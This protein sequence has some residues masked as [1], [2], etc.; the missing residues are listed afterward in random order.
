MSDHKPFRVPRRGFMG[1]VAGGVMAAATSNSL[2]QESIGVS[3]PRKPNVLFVMTDQQRADTI[4]ALGNPDIYSPNFDRLVARGVSFSNGY[5][6]CPVCVPAR[7][8]IRTG[9][10]MPTTGVYHNGAPNLVEGQSEN[11]E[12]RCGPYLA[13]TMAANGYRTFG[14]G[15]FHTMPRFE[16]VGYHVHLHSEEIYGTPEDRANDAFAQYIARVC[17]AYDFQEGLMGE[18]TEMYYMPQ[19]SAMPAE[20]T[21][22][23]W[24]AARAVEQIRRHD[25]DR[26]YFGFV[27]FVGPH[28]PFAPPI[29]FNRMYDPDR[30]P[31]PVRGDRNLDLM[32][33]QLRWMNHAIF[34]DDIS[35]SHARV[36][37]ARYYGELT[38][39]DHCL[40]MILDAVD[41]RDDADNTLICFYS[42]HGDHLGDH[43]AWQK[44]S[45][46]QQSCN[47]PFLLSWPE[48]LPAGTRREDLV[49][50]TDLFGIAT[51]AA[52]AQELRDGVDVIGAIEGNAQPREHLFGYYGIPGTAR[53]KIMVRSGDW[54]YIFM[55]NGGQEQLFNLAE[56][57]QEHKQRI[58][59]APDIA[60]R[61]RTAARKALNQPNA[62]RAL[63]PDGDLLHLPQEDR[64]LRR[65]YQFDASR[66]VRGFPEKPEQVAGLDTLWFDKIKG[67]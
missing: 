31:N 36:C 65:I 12:E 7:Y 27:S 5:S 32:D 8:N 33:E 13:R 34:A 41:A 37:R 53:F 51:T 46:F 18:R 6:A 62:N 38:Y 45:Y 2:A 64:P 16:D 22:E 28:P 14:V 59:D 61:L 15:K 56:D 49:S 30:M 44:E 9:R 47:V 67:V 23:A 29:P 55:A 3:R 63:T 58:H 43:H 21:V 4:A 54:K 19:M 20:H 26:P 17:P 24:A 35:D 39:I 25:D 52:G 11:M 50:L 42:D 66:G 57:P 1:T 48:R 40:G 60:E 10:E